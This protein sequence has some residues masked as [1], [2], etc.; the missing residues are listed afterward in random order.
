[1]NEYDL[2]YFKIYECIL[3]EENM[4]TKH[5]TY[6]GYKNVKNTQSDENVR[7]RF[8]RFIAVKEK[9]I[10]HDQHLISLVN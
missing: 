1:M 4:I 2:K 6:N 5:T 10:N 7:F 3:F 8:S 9:I